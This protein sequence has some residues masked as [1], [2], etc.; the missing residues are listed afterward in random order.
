[1]NSWEC[2]YLVLP[3]Y[4]IRECRYHPV[5]VCRSL[6]NARNHKTYFGSVKN[7][8]CVVRLFLHDRPTKLDAEERTYMKAD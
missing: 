4:D 5:I 3:R 7:V 1:M 2:L 6:R 8:V